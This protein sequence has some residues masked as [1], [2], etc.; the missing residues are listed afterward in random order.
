MKKSE[1]KVLILEDD[2]TVGR[3]LAEAVKR[4]GYDAQL[5]HDA[6]QALNKSDLG[7]YKLAVIDC[8]LPKSSGVDV[9]EKL[10]SITGEEIKII[11]TSG[12]YRDKM[13]IK[14]AMEKSHALAF[15]TKP[16]EIKNILS[17]IDKNFADIVELDLPPLIETLTTPDVSVNHRLKAIENCPTIHGFD[18]P[19][20]YSLIF[21]SNLSGQLIIS[22]GET[23]KS[24]LTFH[25]GLLTQ[26]ELKDKTSYFGALLVEM[27][28][29]TT[30][31]VE[32]VLVEQSHHPIGERLVLAHSLS[33]H[34]IR[35]VRIEQMLI[36]L[37]K[38]IRDQFIDIKFISTNSGSAEEYIDRPRFD[39]ILWDWICSKL[40]GDWL[41]SFYAQWSDYPVLCKEIKQIEARLRY[42]TTTQEERQE[43][44]TLLNK[45]QSL[46]ESLKVSTLSEDR[47]QAILHYLFLQKIVYFGKPV[48]TAA[49]FLAQRLKRLK[50]LLSEAEQKNYFQLLNVS[51]KSGDR[52]IHKSYTELA[53]HFHPDK[54]PLG[55]PEEVRQLTER[56]FSFITQAY[57][58]LKDPS[59]RH[60]YARAQVEGSAEKALESE[61]LMEQAFA[62]LRKGKF[63]G[64]LEI[65]ERL[66]AQKT[67]RQDVYIYFAWAKMKVTAKE[68]LTKAFLSS[69]GE[70]INRV[71]PEDRHS[72]SYLYVKGLY[73]LNTGD[74]D[75]A[76]TNFRHAITMD[77]NFIEARRDLAVVRSQAVE[78]TDALSELSMIVRGF[79]GGNKK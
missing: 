27:G 33:P 13:S 40:T 68:Q 70:A 49:G 16:L 10:L 37:S 26:I 31:E 74:F 22:A 66:I 34:A 48:S 7:D 29:T 8:L 61:A 6:D 39:Q 41:R 30:K 59:R 42:L 78:H 18:L 77:S 1:I 56:Y 72:A 2:P 28:F 32:D 50:R 44:I 62:N 53:Q 75:K 51:E 76:A 38:T 65:A 55:A 45:P 64:A 63:Q 36:R 79:F 14:E 35:V 23:D 9:A 20:V 4:E 24:V 71:P 11:L 69:I 21:G 19:L 57:D 58:T 25:K 47:A 15:F 43:V 52:E 54:I 17:L 73:Y 3:S 46:S 67:H 5:A 12:V 60:E